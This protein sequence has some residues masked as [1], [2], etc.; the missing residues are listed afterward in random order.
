MTF[1]KEE[2]KKIKRL[3][4]DELENTESVD[5]MTIGRECD[6]MNFKKLSHYFGLHKESLN[7]VNG[8]VSSQRVKKLFELRHIY[9]SI[10]PVE[11]ETTIQSNASK[12]SKAHPQTTKQK[13]FKNKKLMS[14]DFKN[15]Q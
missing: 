11:E 8:L 3:F 14:Y 7:H 6:Q 9:N 12:K 13:N 10:E 2:L 1:T 15:R 5:L 4:C